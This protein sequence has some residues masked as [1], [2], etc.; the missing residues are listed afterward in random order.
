MRLNSTRTRKYCRLITH[1]VSAKIVSND[2]KH[3]RKFRILCDTKIKNKV[4][5][6][7]KVRQSFYQI[8]RFFDI[9]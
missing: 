5:F 7:S 2:I 4:K 8:R 1:R 3:Q 6:V 9:L